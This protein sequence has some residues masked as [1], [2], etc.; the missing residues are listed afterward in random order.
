MKMI[1]KHI[2]GFTLFIL[3]AANI[4]VFKSTTPVKAYI[5]GEIGIWNTRPTSS[6]L[7]GL[8]ITMSCS[9]GTYEISS[10]YLR[11]YWR[12]NGGTLDVK[13]L[14]DNG[15]D[16][17]STTIGPFNQGDLI[18][19]RSSAIG[20]DNHG[21][22]VTSYDPSSTGF[23]S[24]TV[25]YLYS[26]SWINP[27][28]GNT[29]TFGEGAG[30]VS[31]TPEFTKSP[32]V[33]YVKL[34]FNDID[35]GTVTSGNPISFTYGVNFDGTITAVLK[36]YD[37]GDSEVASDQRIFTF[38][39][40]VSQE[41]EILLQGYRT[42]GE[43]LYLILHDPSGD[44]SISSYETTST[45]SIGVG[46]EV[47]AGITTGL[48]F[49]VEE[50]GSFFGLFETGF[51]ASTKLEL[52]YEVSAGFDVRYEVVDSTFLSSS[53]TN[54]DPDFIGPGFGDTYWGEAWEFHWLITTDTAT[55][56]DGSTENMNGKMW[57]GILRELEAIYGDQNAP[58][59]WKNLNVVHNGYPENQIDWLGM[60][61]ADGGRQY[62]NTHEVSSTISTSQ[63][64]T[65][66]FS[67]ENR[68]KLEAAGIYVET[69][70]EVS[71]STKIYAEQQF[72]HKI[73]TSYTIEDDDP[74]DH[75]VQRVGIDKRFG[76]YVFETQEDTSYTSNPLESNT[77]DYV[78]PSVGTLSIL[79]DADGD[80]IYPT[81]KDTPI[82]TVPITDEGGIQDAIINYTLDGGNNWHI[83][84][85]E[86]QIGN[87]GTYEGTLPAAPHGTTVE[88]Y[89]QVW[90]V[91]G[92]DVSKKNAQN[93]Y[94]SYTVVNRAPL[95]TVL[96]PNGGETASNLIA[97]S[98]S[99]SDPDDDELT[100]Q[101]GYNIENQGWQLI[102]SGLKDLSYVWNISRFADSSSVM[103]KVI[104]ND[105][106]GGIIEDTNDFAFSID[107]EDTPGVSLLTPLSGFT[108]T[109][110]LTIEWELTDID[111]LVTS[112]DLYYSDFSESTWHEIISGLTK[113]NESFDWNTSPIVYLEG[114]KIKVITHYDMDGTSQEEEDISGLLTI[115]NR[116][117]LILQLIHP[118]GGE[119]WEDQVT[120][121]YSITANEV[122][123]SSTIEY[124]TN[125][126]NWHVIASNLTDTSYEWNT[127]DLDY[128]TNYK[129]RITVTG[130]YLGYQLETV[131]DTSQGSFTI[132]PD[133]E[134]PVVT[135]LNAA[136][137]EFGS[138]NNQITFTLS[139]RNPSKY[140]LM[141]N[142]DIVIEDEEW[143]NGD[144][145]IDID[146]LSVDVYNYT[147]IV[148]DI[149]GQTTTK[150]CCVTVVDTTSPV[151]VISSPSDGTIFEIQDEETNLSYSYSVQ[152]LSD[153]TVVI[154]LND[155]E[156]DDNSLLEDLKPGF[157]FLNLTA[158]DLY[159][160]RAN[161]AVEFFIVNINT[162][163]PVFE[164]T[165][166]SPNGGD[167]V[168]NDILPISWVI[169]NPIELETTYDIYFSSDEGISWDLII[170]NLET[171]SYQWN[172]SLLENGEKY[173]VKITAKAIY[174]GKKLISED[175]SD[176]TFIIIH[177]IDTEDLEKFNTPGFS[178]GIVLL[179]IVCFAV[180]TKKRMG[181]WH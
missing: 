123:Y 158:I 138:V 45:V 170:D 33:D 61:S 3:L 9:F 106:Y 36:G 27:A 172:T 57:Y 25:D 127:R 56:Y 115:D 119:I 87:P 160:N 147:I 41:T 142:G 177:S 100:Y 40:I 44:E 98:W 118:N 141:K 146:G 22:L 85:L 29:I 77:K 35:M 163:E 131:T 52:S 58:Q 99:A 78:T 148:T 48:E 111:S 64:I 34:F 113:T 149:W 81:G 110:T 132:D 136:D 60:L 89:I 178:L 65:L 173:L 59:L 79:L 69:T 14:T 53:N 180:L 67:N 43:K 17:A 130:R 176:S 129:I 137:Y 91:A 2:I 32:T 62:T 47:T 30:P 145:T 124:S 19:Y 23:K 116:P 164:V 139:D 140:S 11:L 8:V 114:V 161:A 95:I 166:I 4:F 169:A 66:S 155:V 10:Y 39:K 84:A 51:D 82:I 12:V 86:E 50:S 68:A 28:A 128:G 168:V 21:N 153:F 105:G 70:V 152:D 6:T 7:P 103:I 171:T 112:F 63:S 46:A 24:F 31:F 120:I 72:S 20:E 49:G 125:G 16:T 157:Y 109:G 1:S 181:K 102:A 37:S 143:S 121:S 94:F 156:I 122:I 108:Y 150:S 90:D 71:L 26:V 13:E 96:E 97:I 159:G 83:T 80:G 174:E 154:T 126:V 175:K 92:N 144:I 179:S 15:D 117:D 165:L 54:D 167:V 38:R 162:E 134:E 88:W 75:I 107:N 74:T 55:Y 18:E 101:V 133:I 104:A 93:E 135:G 151:L 42:L 76:T 5:P 73:E